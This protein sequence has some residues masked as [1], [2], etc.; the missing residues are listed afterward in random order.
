MSSADVNESQVHDDVKEYYGKTLKSSDDLKT[1]ACTLASRR[2]PKNVRDALKLVHEE[3][4][5]K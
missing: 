4:T 1:S 2:I 3:V 5:S